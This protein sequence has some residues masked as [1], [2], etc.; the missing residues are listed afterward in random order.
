MT[1]RVLIVRANPVNPDPRVAK[2]A[3]VLN[4]NQ[5]EVKVLGW[6]Q[7]GSLPQFEDQS[8]YAI[9][10]IRK[11]VIYKRGL[12]NLTLVMQWQISLALWLFRHRTEYD[13][14]HACDFDTVLPALFHKFLYR[15]VVVYDIFDF[16]ADMLKATPE[17]I[18]KLIRKIDLKAI[19][20]ADAVILVDPVRLDQIRGSHPKRIEFIYNSPI[21]TRENIQDKQKPAE[22]KPFSIAYVGL[23]SSDRSLFQLLEILG[24]HPEWQLH[25]GG[26]GPEESNLRELAEK[27]SN[28][29]WYGRI[30][31]DKTLELNSQADVLVA[32]Y[33]P[34][35]PNHK[36]ASP[37][38]LFEAM[39]LAKPVIAA[40]GTNVDEIVLAEGCGLVVPYGDFTELESAF[41]TFQQDR[42]FRVTCGNN[43]RKAYDKKYSWEKMSQRLLSLYRQI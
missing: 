21:D 43:A 1:N 27:L 32:L 25:I 33:D 9:E 40:Q 30:S 5:Y 23:L 16:Y 6:D 12:R 36:Y 24:K 13:V 37:N 19:N 34:A 7:D 42:L 2:I 8:G 17:L 29:C 11:K 15:K 3:K 4:D 18:T 38:K 31:Y 41:L 28:V 39:M 10:R 26:Y 22:E 35:V 14:V 20:A